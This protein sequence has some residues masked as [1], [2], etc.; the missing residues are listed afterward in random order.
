VS[1]RSAIQ[2]KMDKL[3]ESFLYPAAIDLTT[4]GRQATRCSRS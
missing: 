1:A 2:Q 4:Y 3:D